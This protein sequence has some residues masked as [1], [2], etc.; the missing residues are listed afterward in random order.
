MSHGF[1]RQRKIIG[2]PSPWCVSERAAHPTLF[3]SV[4]TKCIE[5]YL[6]AFLV[7]HRIPFRKIHILEALLDLAVIQDPL[8]EVLRRD[9]VKLNPY[10][11]KVRYPGEEA[12]INEA[13][14]AVLLMKRLRRF[15]REKLSLP[16]EP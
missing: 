9:A 8:L 5:K 10:A 6:K 1:I 14:A 15:L 16:K 13:K 4:L 11:V 12:T 7:L 2:Q 3:A